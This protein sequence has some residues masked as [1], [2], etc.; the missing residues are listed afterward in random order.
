MSGRHKGRDPYLQELCWVHI[1][2]GLITS[3]ASSSDHDFIVHKAGNISTLVGLTLGKTTTDCSGASADGAYVV[4][5]KTRVDEAP[6]TLLLDRAGGLIMAVETAD[7]SQLPTDWQWPEPVKL[8]SADGKTDIYGL[9][10]RPSNFSSDKAYPVIDWG[11][12]NPYFGR[13]PKGAFGT[14]CQNGIVYM[15]AAA[16]AELGFI[17]VVIDGRGSCYRSKDFHDESY[18]QVHTSSNLEDHIA[19][20][21]QLAARYPYMDLDRVGIMDLDGSNGPVYGMLAFPDFYKAG[22]VYTVWD[23]RLFSQIECYQGVQADNYA[24]SILCDLASNLRGKLLLM[25][26]MQDPFMQVG[27]S[28]QLVN[29]LVRE[30][31]DFDFLLLPQGGHAVTHSMHYGLRRIWDYLVI[32]LQG[33]SPPSNFRLSSGA[34]IAIEKSSSV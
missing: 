29:A 34:E 15:S 27:G 19:G 18:E 1:D 4:V 21:Q 7:L 2:T 32:H 23:E 6:A 25:H 12:T 14:D 16:L 31:R 30:N 3:L 5:T 26:G 10:F 20:L 22:A 28:L 24:S 33:K 8:L 11:H 9:V 17:A 13:V